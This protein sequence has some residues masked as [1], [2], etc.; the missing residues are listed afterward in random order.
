VR[1]GREGDR[2]MNGSVSAGSPMVD[3]SDM[4]ALFSRSHSPAAR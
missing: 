4:T 3:G 2:R 1:F